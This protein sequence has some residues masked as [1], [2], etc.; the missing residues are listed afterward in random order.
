MK[1]KRT[2]PERVERLRKHH[3]TTFHLFGDWYAVRAYS[4][5]TMPICWYHIK[6][7]VDD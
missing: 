3:Y 6:K 2:V 4:R 5:H 1:N 7:I